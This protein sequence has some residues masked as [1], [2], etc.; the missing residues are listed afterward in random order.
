MSWLRHLLTRRK[1]YGELSEEIRAHLEEK[2]EELVAGGMARKDAEAKARREFG[3]V[4]LTEES[5]R[6]VWRWMLIED[7]FKDVRFGWRMLRKNPGFTAVAVLTLAL[8]I[9]LNAA[10]FGLVDSA[11]LNAMPFHEP[12]SLVHVW[13]TDA[14]G[15][16]HTPLPR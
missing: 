2:V 1:L 7:F 5:G 4:T 10:I 9:G 15:E 14:A 16:T 6:D 3:N 11:L 8:G 12:E 13:T